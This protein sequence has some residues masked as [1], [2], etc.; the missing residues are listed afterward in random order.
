VRI[1]RDAR[2]PA[3]RGVGHLRR[4]RRHDR[5][6]FIEAI[7]RPDP[8]RRMRPRVD[9]HEPGVEL[10]LEVEL[11][12]ETAARLEVSL[13]VALQP[14]DSALGLRVGRP[15]EPPVN[16]QLPAE[17]SERLA[18]PAAVAVNAG[19]AVPDQHLRQ[20]AEPHQAAGDPREQVLVSFEKT[21]TPA[22]ARE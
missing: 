9:L 1:G 7:D 5:E 6:L 21:S 11:V 3:T 12:G 8:E 10:V 4:Q 22:P 15:A 19:L 16:A 13:G 18:W 2:G 14:L 20:R 17:R